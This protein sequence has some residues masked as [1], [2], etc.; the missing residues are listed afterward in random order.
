MYAHC[1]VFTPLFLFLVIIIDL[2]IA[3]N[4]Y[5][6]WRRCQHTSL[7]ILYCFIFLA[8]IFPCTLSSLFSVVIIVDRHIVHF[9]RL[10]EHT[11]SLSNA[12]DVIALA[13]RSHRRRRERTRPRRIE[14]R[15]R[16]HDSRRRRA[17]PRVAF[18][19]GVAE[20]TRAFAE[21]ESIVVGALSPGTEGRS[22][23]CFAMFWCSMFALNYSSLLLNALYRV[24][25]SA[26]VA[27]PRER[28]LVLEG[29]A[30]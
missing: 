3:H 13:H 22:V 10:R 18:A 26:V 4:L 30:E 24:V 2:D 15:I 29:G 25:R 5:Y 19:D 7:H 12:I 21:P 6:R 20:H 9:E 8:L 28:G 17:A 1:C 14:R 27:I 23:V 11:E 16:A